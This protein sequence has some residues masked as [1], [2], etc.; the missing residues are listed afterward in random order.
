MSA[1]TTAVAHRVEHRLER[2]VGL[3]MDVDELADVQLGAVARRCR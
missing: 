3:P 1:V 2:G